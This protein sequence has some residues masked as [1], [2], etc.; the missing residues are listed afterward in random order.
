VQSFRSKRGFAALCVAVGALSLPLAAQASADGSFA[1]AVVVD[2]PSTG[3][4][5]LGDVEMAFDSSGV[6]AYVRSDEGADHA[7]IS[8]LASGS[9][10]TPVRV[11]PGQPAVIGKPVVGIASGG[12][13]TVVYANSAGLWARVQ[14]SPGQPFSAPQQLGGPGANSPSVDMAPITG[15]AYVAWAENGSVRAAYLPRRVTTYTVYAGTANINP[16]NS[17]GSSAELAPKV[18]TSADGTGVVAFGE[19]D[20]ATTRIGV[21]R[22]VRGAFSSVVMSAAAESLDGQAGG[23][24]DRPAIA[25]QADSSFAW[26]VFSQSFAD[27]ARRAV[28]RRVRA[29]TLEAPQALAGGAAIGANAGPTI[30][31]NDRG[32]GII[33]VQGADGTI[34][35]SIIRRGAVT[36]AT[37]L[38]SSPAQDAIPAGAFAVDQHG[39]SAWLQA[40][41]QE[42]VARNI[43]EDDVLPAPPP[44]GATTALSAPTLGAAEA[45]GGLDLA[46]DR[47]GDSVIAFTQGPLGA[48]T[49]AVASFSLP[50]KPVR[51]IGL[52]GW[53]N[54]LLPPLSWWASSQG[55]PAQGY[56]IYIDDLLTGSSTTTSFT[57]VSPL[58][59]GTHKLRVESFDRA[60][61]TVSSAPGNLKVDTTIPLLTVKL[62]GSGSAVTLSGTASDAKPPQ[63]SGLASVKVNFGD[64]SPAV[65]GKSPAF[66]LRHRFLRSGSLTVTV[67][68]T[69]GAGNKAV[70]SGKVKA[71]RG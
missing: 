71:K 59:E 57:P 5:A 3:V 56:R 63:G 40:P 70:F 16:A 55:W 42:I 41:G 30:G 38:G 6:V 9:P 22:L 65:V 31:A 39:V 53:R 48:R 51:L 27:G 20:G 69:D 24:A 50:L 64:G 52:S 29:S 35:A 25:M 14:I 8:M 37:P 13:M 15:V 66:K 34:W 44:F 21:R 26:V 1:G 4:S 10:Q 17:A 12:R 54:T 28:V 60:G 19:A 68:A 32:S 58:G 67:T 36:A 45:G 46:T 23:S 11:D 43:A 62:R 7:F 61:Q 18:S 33:N 47:Y 2:G 49:V